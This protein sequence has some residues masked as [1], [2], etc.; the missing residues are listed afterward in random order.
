M[1]SNKTNSKDTNPKNSKKV[2]KDSRAK[3]LKLFSVL[4][5]ILL[6]GIVVVINIVF[7]GILGKKLTFDFSSNQQNS[8]SSITQ[9]YLDNLPD[10]S[11]IRIVGLFDRPE[12]QNYLEY[13]VP[14]LDDYE[15]KSHGHISVEYIDPETHPSIISELD[16]NNLYDLAKDTY[17]VQYNGRVEVVTFDKCFT[18]DQEILE[19]YGQLVPNSVTTE[20]A[21]T[22]AIVRL[23]NGYSA[24]ACFVTDPNAPSNNPHGHTQFSALLAGLGIESVDLPMSDSFEIPDDCDLLIISGLNVDITENCVAAISDYITYGGK[25]I[26]AVNKNETNDTIEYTNLNA[27]LAMMNLRIDNSIIAESDPSYLYNANSASSYYEFAAAINSN[28]QMYNAAASALRISYCR[29]VMTSGN[30]ASY[31]TTSPVISSSSNS[32]QLTEEG[33][34]N[35]TPMSFNVGMHSSFSDAS[36]QEVYVFGTMNFTS[37]QYIGAY[38][39]ADANI[40]FIRNIVKDMLNIQDTVLVE[41]KPLADYSLDPQKMN[42]N[43]STLI[44]SVFMVVVP[45]AMV[46]AGV[47]VYNKRKNL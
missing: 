1:S 3:E 8:I 28:Y 25:M 37:D 16:P 24:K 26:V 42:N 33:A 29:P 7:D 36:G 27:V 23:V 35:D 47:V 45:L 17:A 11:H 20:A 34:L 41:S 43:T 6:V 2:V 39:T 14:I 9:D 22:N 21:F 13:I 12:V 32:Y 15:A 46:I 31:I 40:V 10:G 38:S 4:S 30:P 5:V 44:T 18:L 19:Y